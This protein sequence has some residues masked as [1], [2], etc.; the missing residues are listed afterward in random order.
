MLGGKIT[1]GPDLF[2]RIM[3]CYFHRK[4][5][6]IVNY[7]IMTVFKVTLYV[8]CIKA[9]QALFAKKKKVDFSNLKPKL[10]IKIFES[11]MSPILLYNSEIWGAFTRI[12]KDFNK[13][14]QTPIEKTHLKFCK[15]Y[16]GINKKATNVACRGELGKF[17]LLINI[18]KRIIKYIIHINTL[19]DSVIVKQAFLLSKN[20]YLN[21]QQS[22]YLNVMKI[23]KS[24][25]PSFELNELGPITQDQLTRYI[26]NIKNKYTCNILETHTD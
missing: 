2:Y 15:L 16:L 4:Y 23:L 11:I 21:N 3:Y 10:A 17:P 12:N 13:W 14:N 8:T 18:H 22:F 25:D 19:P 20:L 1:R 26:N 6:V 5:S 7:S 9:I 24:Y